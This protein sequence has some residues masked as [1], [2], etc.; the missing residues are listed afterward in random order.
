MTPGRRRY[1]LYAML[2]ALGIINF[3]DRI[4]MSVAAKPVALAFGLTPV[5][6]GYLFSSFFWMYVIGLIPG[7]V[8]ADRLGV[9]RMAALA[10]GVWSVM[11]M[12]TGLATGFISLLLVRIGL[13]IGESPTNGTAS[14]T[15]REWA[16]VSERGLAMSI[17]TAGSYAGPAFGA[18]LSAGLIAAVG[19]RLS[20][21]ITG[22]IGF[23]WLAIWL[24]WFH[25]PERAA[26]LSDAERHK[27]IS[28][29]EVAGAFP[30]GATVSFLDL[31]RAPSMWGVA[32]T[33]GCMTYNQ[34]LFLTWLPNYL[35][36]SHHLS[37]LATGYYTTL[38][39]TLAVVISIGFSYLADRRLSAEKVRNG[40]RRHGVAVAMVLASVVALVPMFQ[41]L[42]AILALIVISLSCSA[43]AQA[44][45]FSLTNDL[46]LDPKCV[47]RAFGTLTV[48]GNTFGLLAPIVTGY[49]VQYTGRFD[50][51]F[52]ISGA[53]LLAGS[54][55]VTVMT[56]HPIGL[57]AGA[58][59][60]DA[61]TARGG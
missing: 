58:P 15:V 29:R 18:S 56:R 20:F 28:E 42:S 48:G 59:A 2:F 53:L 30:E 24:I 49:V 46:V 27:I 57:R 37:V 52:I 54:V 9:R 43:T 44:L 21:I 45:N 25:P 36:T 7:G 13:G 14:R 39:Y 16:P 11:Q 35:Q 47:G 19:W 33:Q 31:L 51:T 22:M 60:G 8:A 6:L 12:L 41:S 4:N 32:I 17:M 40:H 61:L 23:A 3:I 26:W 5:Q 1:W 38:A 55:V 50:R 10:I 34:Y